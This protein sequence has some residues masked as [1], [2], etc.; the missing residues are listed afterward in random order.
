MVV[1]TG[2]VAGAARWV[3]EDIHV[4]QEAVTGTE[5]DRQEFSGMTEPLKEGLGVLF[6]RKPG[7]DFRAW[8]AFRTSWH[9][10]GIDIREV[11][12]LPDPAWADRNFLHTLAAQDQ[13]RHPELGDSPPWPVV[14]GIGVLPA[15]VRGTG[16]LA[17]DW[18]D[19]WFLQGT[20]NIF[21][22]PLELLE[23]C[24]F[25]R[26][27][28][29]SAARAFRLR[30]EGLRC[31]NVPWSDVDLRWLL[32]PWY[33]ELAPLMDREPPFNLNLVDPRVLHTLL[34]LKESGVR[35]P[36]ICAETL[37]ARRNRGF[38]DPLHW[39]PEEMPGG[40][41]DTVFLHRWLGSRSRL[42]EISGRAGKRV[43]RMVLSL[44]SQENGN[45]R[46]VSGPVRRVEPSRGEG[47]P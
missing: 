44:A 5:R 2:L 29:A 26:T 13:D 33:G 32:S 4:R 9:D 47:Y 10:R 30:V 20:C 42:F 22:T 34:G 7:V 12:S 16:V 35:R 19:P 21:L 28:D 45:F 41:T 43:F 23:S 24:H 31:N 14:S 25:E 40:C 46:V 39:G 11:S 15:E 27:K 18:Q 17:G 3:L 37:L 38:V 6:Q 8:E 36:D 1:F